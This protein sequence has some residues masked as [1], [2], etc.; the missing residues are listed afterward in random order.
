[1]EQQ[2]KRNSGIQEA[3]PTLNESITRFTLLFSE[4]ISTHSF[5]QEELPSIRPCLLTSIWILSSGTVINPFGKLILGGFDPKKRIKREFGLNALP[6]EQGNI[7]RVEGTKNRNILAWYCGD[8]Y[9]RGYFY[10]LDWFYGIISIDLT[11]NRERFTQRNH[12][13]GKQPR[14]LEGL[15]LV[16]MN[17]TT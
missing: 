17:N 9:Y 5:C 8:Y 16:A 4:F 11:R 1:M 10:V 3:L 13:R 12:S 15:K 2:R 7:N 14:S 6:R